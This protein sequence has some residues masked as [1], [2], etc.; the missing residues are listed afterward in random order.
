MA[1]VTK[2]LFRFADT[3]AR[4]RPGASATTRARTR[5]L[6]I[7]TVFAVPLGSFL[8]L[9]A[10]GLDFT[11][12]SS[13]CLFIGATGMI[14]AVWRLRVT[15][16]LNEASTIF[17]CSAVIG[18]GGSAWLDPEPS[19]VP[20]VL[21]AATPVYF[22]LIVRWQKCLI[23]TA[24]MVLFYFAL[25]YWL[26]LK[27]GIEDTF[28]L[29]VLAC[30]LAVLGVG[31]STMAYANTTERAAL[32]LKQ[33][34]NEIASIAYIDPLTN[35]AN[36]RAFKDAMEANWFGL[37][38][39]SLAMIDLDSFKQINDTHGHEVGDQVL[40]EFAQRLQSLVSQNA[41]L[42]RLGGDEFVCAVDSTFADPDALGHAICHLMDAPFETY[43]GLVPM[44]VSVGV[45]S[46]HFG[47]RGGK[48]MFREADI[49]LY[50]AKRS[51][52]SGWITF[53]DGL[54][55]ISKRSKRLTE[56]LKTALEK[57]E[58]E[59][60]F[61][62]QFDIQTNEIVGFEALARW[63]IDEFGRVSPGE[64]VPIAERANLINALD[65][66][67]FK[68]A[69]KEA[70]RWLAGSQRLAVNISGSTLLS[71]N[72]LAF[73]EDVL[74]AST[75]RYDQLQIEITETEIIENQAAAVDVCYRLR[76]LGCTIALDDFG[77][78]YSSLSHLSALP[79]NVLK[80][81]RSF[82]QKCDGESNLKILK[83]VV[84]LAHNLGLKLVVEGVET[85]WQLEIVR[86]LGCRCVQG[87]Y[88]SR[89][90]PSHECAALNAR[91][92]PA[93][94]VHPEPLALS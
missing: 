34:A 89:P 52:G 76:S 4:M 70:E 40:A 33:Q 84:G 17:I 73:V 92:G 59:V 66:S 79:V 61:Q 39:E 26:S 6:V 31:L 60:N 65:Q 75:L 63:S 36:R 87:F 71:E 54:G 35:V 69:V 67:V 23:Y 3:I 5:A 7:W 42:F 83:S 45:A 44:S 12:A 78:G 85:E 25:A 32:K 86:D 9:L 68:C 74:Q 80:V 46:S 55:S 49:A 81:D 41:K 62:P 38:L 77:T 43:S 11:S 13:L 56:L 14:F 19:L 29:N 37:E 28:I 15:G 18:L 2:S 64:F 24:C 57:D 21:L 20:L 47:A 50:E 30:A 48:Q 72:F 88:F 51:A 94:I 82:V 91:T 90:L 8:L 58:L 1:N 27:P 22:G 53:C 16:Q 10:E 93:E